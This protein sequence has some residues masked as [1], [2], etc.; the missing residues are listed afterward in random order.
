ME[1]R[2][3]LLSINKAMIKIFQVVG[4]IEFTLLKLPIV[5]L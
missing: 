3:K 5:V 1:I 2:K 4:L